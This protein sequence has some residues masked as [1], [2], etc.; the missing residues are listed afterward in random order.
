MTE[1]IS[2]RGLVAMAGVGLALAGCKP[3]ES[4]DGNSSADKKRMNKM[5]GSTTYG[6]N[7]R[8]GPPDINASH[9]KTFEPEYIALLYIGFKSDQSMII[10]HASF[11]FKGNDDERRDRAIALFDKIADKNITFAKLQNGDEPR[12][13]YGGALDFTDFKHFG[14][15]SKTEIFILLHQVGLGKT[16]FGLDEEQLLSFGTRLLETEQLDDGA[17]GKYEEHIR[18]DENYSFFNAASVPAD[19]ISKIAPN[20]FGALIR[21]RNYVTNEHGPI[22]NTSRKYALNI[23]YNVPGPTDRIPMVIDPDTGNGTGNEP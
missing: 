21:V 15:K 5:G 12:P 13:G 23:H 4:S 11:K 16:T 3:S 6:A 19:K 18:A 22:V 10:N 2:R 7:P 1:E 14:F 9:W 17:G 20:L 8:L